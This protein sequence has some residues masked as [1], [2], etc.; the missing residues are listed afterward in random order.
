MDNKDEIYRFLK[1]Q[2]TFN[3]EES[4]EYMNFL[5]EANFKTFD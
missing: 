3:E 5:Y 1:D 2:C 4:C